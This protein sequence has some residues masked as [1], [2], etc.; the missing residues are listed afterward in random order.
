[1]CHSVVTPLVHIPRPEG[2]RGNGARWMPNFAIKHTCPIFWKINEWAA[3]Y[4]S[5]SWTI[6]GYT[7]RGVDQ[8]E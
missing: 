5:S 8:A 1:M 2:S 3:Q 6:E 4:N 7:D